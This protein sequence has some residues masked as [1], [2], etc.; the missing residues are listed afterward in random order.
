MSI[1]VIGAA[2]TVL[3]ILADSVYGMFIMAADIVYVILFPQLVAI[4]FSSY[5]NTYSAIIGYFVGPI[6][7][8]GAGEPLLNL[9]PVIFYPYYDSDLGQLFPFRTFAMLCSLLCI[10]GFSKLLELLFTRCNLP[11]RCNVLKCFKIRSVMNLNDKPPVKNI[12]Y[13]QELNVGTFKI[14]TEE[15]R[16]LEKY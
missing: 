4:I 6:L 9:N 2:A 8:L 11:E 7:R 3:A 5:S 14:R 13:V 1:V 16:K 12:E 10:L 15:D